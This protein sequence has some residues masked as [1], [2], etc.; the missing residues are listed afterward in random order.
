MEP[1]CRKGLRAL[2]LT[3]VLYVTTYA[4][5]S[6]CG[7]YVWSQSGRFRWAGGFAVTDC[8]IWQPL[9]AHGQRF[10]RVDGIVGF[11]GNHLGFLFYPLIL[12]DHACI[13]PIRFTF[14]HE[15][16]KARQAQ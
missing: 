12:I 15:G 16:D 6:A 1:N 11:R 4:V 3:L 7:K 10:Q 14:L 13:H 9:M 5:L 2:I 8:V